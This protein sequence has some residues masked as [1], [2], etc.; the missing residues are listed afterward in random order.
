MT[1][2]N[3]AWLPASQQLEQHGSQYDQSLPPGPDTYLGFPLASGMLGIQPTNGTLHHQQSRLEHSSTSTSSIPSSA[4][5]TPFS[6]HGLLP[7]FNL[8][9]HAP[10]AASLPTLGG[11]ST[12]T[13][14]YPS[15]ASS[16][17]S[18]AS[19]FPSGARPDSS[20]APPNAAAGGGGD[21]NQPGHDEGT[22][23][24]D[25]VLVAIDD[26]L[27]AH[28]NA[29]GRTLSHHMNQVVRLLRL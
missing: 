21:S 7:D 1:G 22:D 15:T 26:L 10:Q 2:P 27:R 3:L 23:M 20:S 28:P 24:S 12:P 17:S 9:E 4:A 8:L 25:G 14:G 5:S 29:A 11:S 18:S 13:V 16:S 6:V 19:T